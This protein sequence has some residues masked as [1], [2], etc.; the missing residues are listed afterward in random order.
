QIYDWRRRFR[1]GRLTAPEDINATPAFAPLAVDDGAR[2]ESTADIIEVAIG[3][4]LIRVGRDASEAHLAMI[5]R[6][7]RAAS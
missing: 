1:S 3:E 5:F 7:V 2:M 6:A 4:V